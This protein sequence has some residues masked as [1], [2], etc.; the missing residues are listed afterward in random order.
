MAR[1]RSPGPARTHPP[2]RDSHVTCGP[3]PYIAPSGA[4]TMDD[5][6]VTLLNQYVRDGSQR[7]FA[8]LSRRYIDLVYSSARRQVGDAELAEDVTQAVFLALAKKARCCPR[9]WCCRAGSLPQRG[10]WLRTREWF[11]ARRRH[12]E[13]RAAAMAETIQHAADADRG[14]WSEIEPALDEAIA[15]LPAAQRD[16]L[17]L[18]YFDGKSVPEVARALRITEDAAKQRISRAVRLLRAAL[19]ARG[20]RVASSAG[21]AG[22]WWPRRSCPLRRR[23][24]TRPARQRRNRHCHRHRHRHRHC[25]GGMAE[26]IVVVP[27]RPAFAAGAAVLVIAAAVV[28][29]TVRAAKSPGSTAGSIV[30]KVPGMDQVGVSRDQVY[31]QVGG[32]SLWFD[33]YRPAGP[34]PPNGWPVVVLIH[35]GPVPLSAAPEGLGGVPRLRPAPRRLGSGRGDL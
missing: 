17:V 30:Y 14:D 2:S 26:G 16:A 23:C 24:C 21:L 25:R 6:D 27:P 3:P 10:T 29:L 15:E 8:E 32:A 4:A 11:E 20:V 31:R 1:Y 35:G 28:A 5:D 9:R 33:L 7:A 22:R 12:H 18:K 34:A 19:A 13:R